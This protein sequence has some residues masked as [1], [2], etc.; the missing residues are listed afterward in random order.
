MN[1][2]RS[3]SLGKS[4]VCSI[5]LAAALGLAACGG[6]SG[7]PTP[8]PAPAPAPANA[9]PSFTSP[10]SIS[11]LENSRGTAYTAT[12]TDADGDAVSFTLD[13]GPDAALFTLS[14][15]GLLKFRSTPNYDLF[16]DSN[17]DNVYSVVVKAS[18][19]KGGTATQS[20]DVIVTNSR[21]GISVVRVATGFGAD[22][23]IAPRY[24]SDSVL[25]VRQD[26]QI[27]GVDS[28]TGAQTSFVNLFQ[29]GE[30]GRVLAF[31]D[32][33]TISFAL[34]EVDGVGIVLRPVD[35][36]GYRRGNSLT[37]STDTTVHPLGSI[38]GGPGTRVFVA[39]GDP[40]GSNA[41]D[42]ASAFGKLY[43]VGTDPYCGASIRS[44][45]ISITGIGDGIHAPGGG[46]P[47]Q[48]ST[49]LFD[50]GEA[51]REELTLFDPFARPLDLGWPYY[52]GDFARVANAPAQVNGPNV[53]YS[54]G[55][56]AKHGTG[57]VGGAAYAG[58]ISSLTDR[59]VFADISGK[60][61]TVPLS[62]LTDGILHNA[63]EIENRSADFAP[64]AG[65]IDKPRAVVVDTSKRLFILDADG[66][67]FRVDAG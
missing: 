19:G 11:V 43:Q 33:K 40:D 62:F 14:R 55:S 60:I 28:V 21:E 8:S 3:A 25:V 63:S 50:R 10:T 67:L 59:L 42:A 34:L 27:I 30:S 53:V 35:V 5:A 18:D 52:E 45:C 57:I 6:D 29:T 41:Q 36:T 65:S 26:G 31:H 46:A 7:S 20:V 66:E 37:L 23:L 56:G 38:F 15:A 58:A 64:D 17:N 22:A 1:S 9:A 24:N 39:L 13:G 47:Y 16:A 49:I 44:V 48:N 4:G 51:E 32:N 61:F 12:A 54:R 2:V